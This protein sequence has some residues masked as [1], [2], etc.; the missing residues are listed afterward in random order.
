MSTKDNGNVRDLREP[1]GL[2][3]LDD[4]DDLTRIARATGVYREA[5][6]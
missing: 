6:A 4:E 1:R 5:G 2:R 3:R